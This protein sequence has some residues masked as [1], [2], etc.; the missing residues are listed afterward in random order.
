MDHEGI[1][2]CCD[3]LGLNYK[4]WT[5]SSPRGQNL[6]ISCPLA[7]IGRHA[8]PFDENCGC[9]VLIDEEGPS[10]AR[11]FSGNCGYKGSFFNLIQTTVLKLPGGASPAQLELLKWL[12][13]NDTDSIDVRAERCVRLVAD[14][15]STASHR[16]PPPNKHDRDVLDEE[17]FAP[18]ANNLPQYA[19]DRGI[20]TDAAKV[21]RLGYDREGGRLVFSVRRYDGALI[22][23]TGRIVPSAQKLMAAQGRYVPKYF[24]YSGLNK[25]RYLYGAHTWKKERPVVLVEGPIDAVRVWMAIGDRVN[26][27]GVL[28]EG[29]SVDHRRQ[30]RAA[31]PPAGYLFGDGDSAGRRM[32]EKIHYAMADTMPLF[33]MRCPTRI[34][35]DTDGLMVEVSTDPGELTDEEIVLAYE[36]ATLIFGE[37]AWV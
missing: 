16:I 22:G 33:L 23:L 27:G 8:D 19:I 26:V 12:A 15:V 13:K 1:V 29:F 6:A 5:H 18:F 36:E 2:R 7:L 3:E 24:N 32:V 10:Y 11:C 35:E 25:T 34:E 28:G 17:V 4:A 30:C 31:W 20:S 21:W 14:A 9:S 37:V